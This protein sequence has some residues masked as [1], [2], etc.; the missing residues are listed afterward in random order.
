[1]AE[2]TLTVPAEFAED[3]RAAIVREIA[4]DIRWIEDDRRRTTATKHKPWEGGF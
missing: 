2:H 4:L 3:F 1:M